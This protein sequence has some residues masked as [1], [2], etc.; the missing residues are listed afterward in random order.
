MESKLIIYHGSDHE[1][2]KPLF[3]FGKN[4]ND[5]G[6]GFY[7]TR[8]K[9]KADDWAMV[10]GTHG[11]VTNKYEIDISG[12]KVLDLDKYGTLAWIATI[13]KNRGT[14]DELAEITGN[15]IVEKYK[16]DTSQADIIIGYRAD[17]S[18][19]DVADAFLRN[20]LSIN[21]VDRLFHKGDLGKQIFIQSPSAFERIRFISSEEI[22]K[23]S[24]QCDAEIKARIEVNKYLNNR[25]K[26]MMLGEYKIP[27]LTAREMIQDDFHYDCETKS[28]MP[29]RKIPTIVYEEIIDVYKD[30]LSS[31]SKGIP[32][33]QQKPPQ[34]SIHKNPGGTH[35]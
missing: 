12:L 32:G 34:T 18:Y 9:E 19:I 5:Y 1:I 15:R 8:H 4:D 16:I 28:Y 22:K 14:R 11:A 33:K 2:K 30:E 21:E 13:V 35:L 17:D 23:E 31:I 20:E 3:G 26:Q 29:G 25:R 7:C 27:G 6:L 10:N 24:A